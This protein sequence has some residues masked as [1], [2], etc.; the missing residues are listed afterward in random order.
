MKLGDGKANL[1]VETMCS[2]ADHKKKPHDVLW[3][4]NDKVYITWEE[5]EKA[6]QDYDYDAGFGSSKVADDLMVVGYSWWLERY[7]YGGAEGW[8][9]K[10]LPE[11]PASKG[12][13][14]INNRRVR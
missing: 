14:A 1:R 12:M 2:L 4:G 10:T 3:V 8:A 7:E 13:P 9:F 11:R 5:F 6:A